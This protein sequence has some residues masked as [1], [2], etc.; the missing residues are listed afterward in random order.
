MSP[1]EKMGEKPSVLSDVYSFGLV[2]W[3]L[4][5]KEIPLAELG[6]LCMC[7]CL[8]IVSKESKYP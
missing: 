1:E 5:T 3:Q 6:V 4:V 7:V 8:V 2:M